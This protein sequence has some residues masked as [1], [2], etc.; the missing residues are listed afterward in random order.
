[1]VIVETPNFFANSFLDNLLDLLQ[2]T[3]SSVKRC[4]CLLLSRLSSL[5]SFIVAFFKCSGFTQRGLSQRCITTGLVESNPLVIDIEKR[6]A[7]HCLGPIPIKP[8]PSLSKPPI[9][10]QQVSVLRTLDQNLSSSDCNLGLPIFG[11]FKYLPWYPIYL[12]NS[13]KGA[14]VNQ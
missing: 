7:L 3:S 4:A 5:F 12:N 8:Y 14:F 10:S 6:C 13:I 2:R 9:H 1:M 11:L